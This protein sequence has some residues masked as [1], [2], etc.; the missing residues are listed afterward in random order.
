MSADT[1][2]PALRARWSAAWPK[3]MNVWSRFTRLGEP[4]WCMS[5][6]DAAKEGLTE[7]FAMIRFVDQ[8]VVINLKQVA[9]LG[10]DGYAPEIL[11]HEIGHHILAPANLDDHARCI[12]RMRWALPTLEAQANMVANLYTDLLIN[13]RLQRGENLR[14]AEVYIQL[15]NRS[16]SRLWNLYMRMYEIL[17]SLQKG[18]LTQISI[19]DDRMEGDALLGSRVVRVYARDWLDGAGRFAALVLPY[20]LEEKDEQEKALKV[21]QDTR[22][23]G[24]GGIPNGLVDVDDAEQS[25]AIHPA[26]DPALNGAGD[27]QNPPAEEKSAPGDASST[28]TG[29]GQK[30]EPYQYGEI[31]RALG[32]TLTDHEIAVKYYRE[33]AA[34]YLIKFPAKEIPESSEPLPE[35]LA[36]WEIGDPLDTADWFESVLRSPRVV[37]GVTTFQRVYGTT[38]GSLPER[39]PLYLDLYVDSSGSMPNPQRQ[40]SFLTLAGAIIALSALRAGARVQA[41]LWSGK[42]QFVKTDGFV[43]DETEVLRILTGYFGG[44]TQFP[45]PILRETYASRRPSDAP[46]HIFHISDDGIST[47]F[48]ADEKNNSGW[49]VAAMALKKARGGG[50]MALA[51]PQN[52]ETLNYPKSS[53]NP[54]PTILKA[55]NEQ[56][57]DVNRIGSWDEL[58]A[59]ARRFSQKTYEE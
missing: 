56:G 49:N 47:M 9:A 32:V 51:I 36:P 10:L 46:V 33:R 1:S 45:I 35:G 7:S 22:D 43:R 44:S 3:A 21:W 31:L 15:G 13:D 18:T 14:M 25:G 42:N 23:A 59:F 38:Q 27:E 12:A 2:L 4:V 48:E 54:L 37:P 41:T 52:W 30:R 11:A 8:A 53:Y 24:K 16:K 39:Q 20:L 55:R 6:E 26:N 17:W 28:Q 19:L 57:W 5:D 34:P 50:T 40:T 58:V 29:G